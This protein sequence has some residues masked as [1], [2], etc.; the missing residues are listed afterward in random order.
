[1][2]TNQLIAL[3]RNLPMDKENRR[4]ERMKQWFF[5]QIVDKMSKYTHSR[6]SGRHKVNY[7]L[8]KR[9][10]NMKTRI[11]TLFTIADLALL[12]QN[13][14][15]FD[16]KYREREKNKKRSGNVFGLRDASLDFCILS[17]T[18]TYM[19][20]FCFWFDLVN[21]SHFF[22]LK[23]N[24]FSNRMN[25][26]KKVQVFRFVFEKGSIKFF[27]LYGHFKTV[28]IAL[29]LILLLIVVWIKSIR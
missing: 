25:F 5:V 7:L 21:V 27:F 2:Q 16:S 9:D 26:T 23:H 19:G 3:H 6:S 29:E 20:N 12:S 14:A 10:K 11:R 8:S 18:S 15:F 24:L 22:P 17:H 13:C 1:M 4:I 28:F